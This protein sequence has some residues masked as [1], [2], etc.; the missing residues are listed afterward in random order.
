MKTLINSLIALTGIMVLT[1]CT[2]EAPDLTGAIKPPPVA[3]PKKKDASNFERN[4]FFERSEFTAQQDKYDRNEIS[5]R[6]RV[7]NNDGRSVDKLSDKDFQVTEN[8]VPVQKFTVKAHEDK[9][10]Q[11]VDIVFAVDITGS[12]GPFI[13]SAKTHLSEF[14]RK[15]HPK[16]HI[17]MCL[18]TFG[19]KIV[20]KCNRFYDNSSPAQVKEFVDQLYRLSITKGQGE[21]PGELDYEENSLRALIEAAQAPWNQDSQRFVILVSDADFY[22]PEKPSKFFAEHQAREDA[23][24]RSIKDVNKTVQANGVKVF[25]VTPSASG[26]NSPLAGEPDITS[27]SQGEWFEFQKVISKQIKLDAIFDKILERINTT[28]LLSYVVEQNQ[29][30]SPSLPLDKREIQISAP[31]GAVLVDSVNSSMPTGRPEYKKTWKVSDQAL[32][33]ESVNVWVDN[34]KL[35]K[36][37]FSIQNGEISLNETPKPGAKLRFSYFY[38]NIE[39]NLPLE[40]LIFNGDLNHSN[41][42]VWLNGKEARSEDVIFE[43]DMDGDT[44]VKLVNNV[45]GTNDPYEIRKNE[46]LRIR[47]KHQP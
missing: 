8:N 38:E 44:S 34:K 13:Q 29:G 27:A 14:I 9:S 11:V 24:A 12:M 36:S 37:E 5:A 21:Y 28:Y 7:K 18:S 42:K 32:Q 46:S 2:T 45:L 19:D 35:D 40:P 33:G 10:Y 23:S 4:F 15:T 41:T 16:Y 17:R 26:Y 47:I 25:T 6:F 3:A 30:I 39:K 22:S 43:K 31:K 1:N 20:Q